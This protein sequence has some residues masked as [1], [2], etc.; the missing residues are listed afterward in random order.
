MALKTLRTAVLDIAYEET[1]PADGTAVLLM[2][3]FPYAPQAFA[4]VAPDLAASGCRVL[5]PYL[6]GY[7]PTRFFSAA[8]MRSGQQAALAQD[9]LDLLD[10]LGIDRILVSGYDW[11]GRGAA[12][13]AALHPERVT[14]LVNAC[15]Y[16]IQNIAKALEPEDPLQERRLW[17]QYYF[18]SERA[19]AGLA[20]NRVAFAKLLWRLWSPTW[21]FDDATFA[22]SA[23][24][25]DNPDFVDVVIHS[26]RHR[27]GAVAGDPAYQ[28]IE[29]RL[30]TFPKISVPT[31]TF[32][33]ADD[34]VTLPVS[35]EAH[36]RHFTGRYDR[37]VLQ[38]VG[39]N[40]PQEAPRVWA[41][42]ILELLA[43]RL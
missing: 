25:F 31:V 41:A 4:E 32:H 26:Y 28:A 43:V 8:T 15:G 21:A 34:E 13:L 38:G 9:A 24:A 10:G 7:G 2:H 16:V 22:R 12:I 19:R 37:R 29:D 42:A 5:M 33:G 23:P 27:F 14:G 20:Q 1:G 30:A 3:G 40:I 39:H 36:E 17:Y 18:Q 6:R 35:S 11:G